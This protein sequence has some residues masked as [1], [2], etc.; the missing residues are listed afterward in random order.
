[1]KAIQVI[2]GALN[3]TY[4]IHLATDD[5]FEILFL[6]GTDIQCIE[7]IRTR[8]NRQQMANILTRLWSREIDKK[9]V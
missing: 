2:D 6:D 4:P 8:Q 7:D 1:L 5:E 9:D 3:C